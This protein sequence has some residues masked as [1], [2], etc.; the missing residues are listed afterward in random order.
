MEWD[1]GRIVAGVVLVVLLVPALAGMSRGLCVL[2]LAIG[3]AAL[4]G[5][6]ETAVRF[7]VNHFWIAFIPLL[8][9]CWLWGLAV[10]RWRRRQNRLPQYIPA[11]P[12]GRSQ[13]TLE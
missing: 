9:V 11:P 5:Y 2:L 10:E 13:S 4:F 12:S 6:G 1:V 3:L 8:A 7:L